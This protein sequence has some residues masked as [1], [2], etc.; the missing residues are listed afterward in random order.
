[1]FKLLE[2]R[3][4]CNF[5]YEKN[6]LYISLAGLASHQAFTPKFKPRVV[7][8][9]SESKTFRCTTLG[10][11]EHTTT[12]T[13]TPHFSFKMFVTAIILQSLTIMCIP[14]Q[15]SPANSPVCWRSRYTDSSP[16]S[17]CPLGVIPGRLSLCQSTMQTQ[18]LEWYKE[19]LIVVIYLVSNPH[20]TIYGYNWLR[21]FH[22]HRCGMVN[23]NSPIQKAPK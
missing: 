1:M 7:S 9:L 12:I 2:I 18:D 19:T 20:R 6:L 8:Q 15:T 22:L 16:H 13:L 3:F 17:S 14:A 5:H 23:S 21:C 4:E 10:L 11:P